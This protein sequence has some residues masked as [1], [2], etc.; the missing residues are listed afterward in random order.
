MENVRKS[1]PDFHKITLHFPGD[2]SDRAFFSQ[3]L[4]NLEGSKSFVW[5]TPTFRTKQAMEPAFSFSGF[6]LTAES[7]VNIIATS[8]SIATIANLI[9]TFLKDRADKEQSKP[10]RNKVWISSNAKKIEISGDFSREDI[11]KILEA[12][13]KVDSKKAH[14]WFQKQTDSITK[15]ELEDELESLEDAFPKYLKLLELYE[16][17]DSLEPWQERDY[18]KYKIRMENLTSRIK[19]L[20]RKLKQMEEHV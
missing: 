7:I 2:N 6:E 16:N 10:A 3:G 11:V 1:A 9:Y 18:Q 15:S 8:G 19:Q 4:D 5:P 20:R 14:D 17:D 13:E 12:T